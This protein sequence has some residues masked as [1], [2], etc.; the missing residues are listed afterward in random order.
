MKTDRQKAITYAD[1][2]FRIFIKF[3]DDFTCTRCKK[4]Y[5]K[6]PRSRSIQCSHYWSRRH[7]GTRWDDENAEVLCGGCHRIIEGDK[8][9]WYQDYKQ[10]QLGPKYKILKMRANTVTKYTPKEIILI[11]DQLLKMIKDYDPDA[12]ESIT[13]P[14]I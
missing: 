7:L 13:R 2:C 6:N 5:P 8:Q 4:Q 10:N 11:G 9:G 3:R 14:R 12:A 1:D